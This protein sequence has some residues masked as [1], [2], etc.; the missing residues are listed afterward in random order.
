MSHHPAYTM[1]ALC[2]VGGITGYSRTR[3]I[4][5]LVAGISVGALYGVAGYII[6]E[7]RD[8]G[9]ELAVGASTILAISSIPRA[10]KTRKPVPIAL[11]ITSLAAGAYYTKKVIDYA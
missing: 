5:S 9:H 2:V 3:S 6:K 7:N 10:I 4:P 8:Y 11:A 1:S